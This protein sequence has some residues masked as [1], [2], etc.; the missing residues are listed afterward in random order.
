MLNS[1][2]LL[3]TE[4]DLKVE[5]FCHEQPHVLH[6]AGLLGFLFL[7]FGQYL[8]QYLM[9]NSDG[10]FQIGPAALPVRLLLLDDAVGLPVGYALFY[11]L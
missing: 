6:R 11:L 10:V 9:R 1:G 8:H 5:Q 4:P 3:V 2:L 7:Q